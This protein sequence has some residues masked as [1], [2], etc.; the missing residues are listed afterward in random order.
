MPANEK[1]IARM[2]C[3]YNSRTI[4][5]VIRVEQ[6]AAPRIKRLI[7][8]HHKRHPNPDSLL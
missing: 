6:A 1:T 7:L 3:S 5:C 4:Q 8:R 2:A